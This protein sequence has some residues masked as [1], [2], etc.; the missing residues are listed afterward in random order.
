GAPE[1]NP[2]DAPAPVQWPADGWKIRPDII[3]EGPTFTV[4]AH[5]KNNV[6]EWNFIT[7]PSGIEQDT[8]ITSMEIRPSEPSVTHHICVFFRPHTPDVQYDTPVWYDRPRDDKGNAPASAAG[9][10]GRGIPL[11][12]TAGSNGI[13]GCY[14]PGQQT[15][16]YRIHHA[17]KLFKAGTDIVFQV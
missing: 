9:A 1:G 14:V 11:S 12:I 8:W 5:P 4:P 2:K 15:Q 10:N 6:I 16:D 7:V 3:V 17:G 13:E